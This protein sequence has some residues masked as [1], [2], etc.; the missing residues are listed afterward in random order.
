MSVIRIQ[1]HEKSYVVLDKQF[2]FDKSISCS[3]KGFLAFCISQPDDWRFQVSHLSKVLKEKRDAIFSMIKEGI[4]HGYIKREN[5]T[6]DD[7]GKFTRCDYAVFEIKQEIQKILPQPA[8]P[9]TDQ[10]ESGKPTLLTNEAKPSNDL[11]K[12]PPLTPPIPKKPDSKSKTSIGGGGSS[13]SLEMISYKN[14]SGKMLQITIEELKKHLDEFPSDVV[15]KAISEIEFEKPIS[16]IKKYTESI[17]KRIASEAN[18]PQTKTPPE[19]KTPRRNPDEPN[20]FVKSGFCKV[21][22]KEDLEKSQQEYER[23]M[24]IKAKLNMK[25]WQIRKMEKEA[26]EPIKNVQD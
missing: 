11:K 5:Q 9:Y 8:F 15:D 18:I 21:P 6:R 17:C 14:R 19:F 1:R 26:K 24:K 3:L 13:K 22:S 12:P 7:K 16:N 10:A 2:L 23:E 25:A 4:E 20:I